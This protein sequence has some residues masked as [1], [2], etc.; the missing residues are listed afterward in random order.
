MS[1]PYPGYLG[2]PMGPT[3]DNQ[4]Q[5]AA[6]EQQAQSPG[7]QFLSQYN[8]PQAMT[9]AFQ[10][11]TPQQQFS[12]VN[13]L[14]GNRIESNLIAGGVP[15]AQVAKFINYND[16]TNPG[17]TL[18]S[19]P[20][21]NGWTGQA[22]SSFA[23]ATGADN[24]GMFG[25]GASGAGSGTQSATPGMSGTYQA[26]S[27]PATLGQAASGSGSSGL[28]TIPLSSSASGYGLDVSAYQ[29]PMAQT[30]QDWA[31]KALQGTYAGAGDLLSGPAMQG[32]T[33]YNQQ[34][35]LNN[36]YAPALAAAQQKQGTG[37]GLDQYNQQFGYNQALNNQTIPFNQQLQQAQM[38]LQGAAGQQGVT[39]LNAQ[40][41]A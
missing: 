12:L 24:P 17:N 41:Q 20:G 23:G 1:T 21:M 9:A 5:I 16:Y 3:N 15:Q 36:S 8:N 6:Y 14:G 27:T 19:M 18:A 11:M 38:G 25:A 31:N 7:W 22:L 37:I 33:Q 4:H 26:T 39:N 2:V 28:G 29:N 30:M 13:G 10:G 32:I 35:A 34:A 40:L